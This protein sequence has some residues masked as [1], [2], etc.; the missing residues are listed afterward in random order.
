MLFATPPVPQNFR[1]TVLEHME[2]LDAL[3]R[4]DAERAR[5]VMAEHLDNVQKNVLSRLLK[6]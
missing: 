3:A 2:L 4:G 5:Q 6:R 1:Q